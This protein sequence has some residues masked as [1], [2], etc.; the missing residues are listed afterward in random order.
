MLQMAD[1]SDVLKGIARREGVSYPVLTPNIKVRWWYREVYSFRTLTERYA[2]RVST[3]L[4]RLERKRWPSLAR[5][6][7]RLAKRTSTARSRRAWSASA[8]SA[9]RRADSESVFVGEFEFGCQ[10]S[11]SS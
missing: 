11:I 6:P 1:N 10:L 7:R 5:R 3:V 9:R 2:C 8:Q 4:W